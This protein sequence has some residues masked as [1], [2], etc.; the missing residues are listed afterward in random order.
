MKKLSK[1]LTI[2]FATLLLATSASAE[3]AYTEWKDVGTAKYTYELSP[4][5][6]THR[7]SVLERRAVD[8]DAHVQYK[9]INW[10]EGVFKTGNPGT[11]D[12]VITIPNLTEETSTVYVE[13][14]HPGWVKENGARLYVSDFYHFLILY[15]QPGHAEQNINSSYYDSKTKKFTLRLTYYTETLGIAMSGFEYLVFDNY[16][17]VVNIDS[18]DTQCAATYYDLS[19]RIVTDPQPGI[20]I[21][22][23]GDKCTKVL[24]R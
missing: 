13:E 12:F 8:N 22:R 7:L 15:N 11:D 18:D 14:F 9:L 5:D 19:G 23:R 21:E 24:I 16:S 17:G 4:N 10:G 20:Y 6:P 2:S 3:T 1:S